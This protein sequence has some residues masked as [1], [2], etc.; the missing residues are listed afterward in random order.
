MAKIVT[1]VHSKATLQVP[2]HLLIDKCDLVVDDPKSRV[3]VSDFRE[4]V[5]ALEGTTV[6]VT[7]NNIKGLLQLCEAF[8]LQDLAA[9]LSQFRASED[10]KNHTEAQLAIPMT[11]INQSGTLFADRFM[12]TSE[13]A[14]YGC[15]AGQAIALS[16][17]VREQLSD[18]ACAR[19]FALNDVSAVDSVRCLPSGDAVSM[20]RSRNGLGRQLCSLGL[21]L[22][23]A[24]TDRF[25]L[26]SIDLSVFSVEALDEILSLVSFSIASE[27]A[28]LERLLSL[29]DEYRPLVSRIEIRFLSAIGLVI[30]AEHFAF[31]PECVS[32]R[33]LDHFTWNSAIVPDFPRLF[34]EF[35]KKHFTPFSAFFRVMQ[36][37]SNNR[38]MD[39]GGN[40]AVLVSNWRWQ[41]RIVSIW[42]RLT[43]QFS[44]LRN[45][46]RFWVWR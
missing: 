8:R 46:T 17:A 20:E 30:L 9:Q 43:F 13:N 31:P 22:G 34:A 33:I 11:E 32:C 5:S 21:E 40:S 36:F 37:L 16:P 4:F 2:V 27:D 1:L 39:W 41:R 19:T 24:G 38:E 23:L 15:S 3:S 6:K 35:K 18:D 28:L 12:F 42:I 14:I 45:W 25:D 26:D 29:G 7:N 10:F 44:R